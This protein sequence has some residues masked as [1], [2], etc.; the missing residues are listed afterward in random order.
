MFYLYFRY[1]RRPLKRRKLRRSTTER[2]PEDDEKNQPDYKKFCR[3]VI[4]TI[5]AN[6]DGD[7]FRKVSMY[8]EIYYLI[9]KYNI[10]VQDP[11]TD[12]VFIIDKLCR[13]DGSLKRKVPHIDNTIEDP[14]T[15]SFVY[16]S[17]TQ[18][19]GEGEFTSEYSSVAKFPQFPL[20]APTTTSS[21]QTHGVYVSQLGEK[22]PGGFVKHRDFAFSQA[23]RNH[24]PRPVTSSPPGDVYPRVVYSG[25]RQQQQEEEEGKEEGK[26]EGEKE[27]NKDMS[28][29]VSRPDQSAASRTTDLYSSEERNDA[30]PV[31]EPI[32]AFPHLDIDN[33]KSVRFLESGQPQVR[34]LSLEVSGWVRTCNICNGRPTRHLA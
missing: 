13:N 5:A 16:H 4:R 14:E 30:A 11:A 22:F 10:P 12:I 27:N 17:N 3:Q 6:A 18:E 23:E 29:S 2:Y 15:N 34:K 21:P 7:N 20:V 33:I 28:G 8:Q 26:E 19:G 9:S 31:I 32:T 1:H 25:P 24:Q